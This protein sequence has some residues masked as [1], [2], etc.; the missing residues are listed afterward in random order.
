MAAAEPEVLDLTSAINAWPWK[1]WSNS[2]VFRHAPTGFALEVRR[3]S[4]WTRVAVGNATHVVNDDGSLCEQM[5]HA[6]SLR[7][8]EELAQMPAGEAAVARSEGGFFFG[9]WYIDHNAQRIAIYHKGRAV[10]HLCAGRLCFKQG[11]AVE[12]LF[13][14]TSDLALPSL[15][16]TL[17]PSRPAG[18]P[19]VRCITLGGRVACTLP[20]AARQSLADFR[21]RMMEELS[22]ASHRVRLF[23]A[24]GAFLP[25]SCDS[26]LLAALLGVQE[27]I[28]ADADTDL[29][30][31]DGSPSS[32]RTVGDGRSRSSTQAEEDIVASSSTSS[33]VAGAAANARGAGGAS[34][35]MACF[36]NFAQLS[37]RKVLL[38]CIS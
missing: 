29:E 30:A 6:T 20:L 15:V 24:G 26:M 16:Y 25:R 35:R 36:E 21:Q 10:Y 32:Q 7:L 18:L 5:F 3:K 14:E 28:G 13:E 8:L 37:L 2:I 17:E 19:E 9:S 4:R 22:L 11:G 27:A 12:N 31:S 1:S 23:K 38:A 33:S 34:C